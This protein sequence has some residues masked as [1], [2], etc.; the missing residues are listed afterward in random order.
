[1]LVLG[2]P[3]REHLQADLYLSRA[4]D[5]LPEVARA[6]RQLCPLRGDRPTLP[7]R[8]GEHRDRV[9]LGRYALAPV[10]LEGLNVARSSV[11]GTSRGVV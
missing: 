1:M 10:V 3:V 8:S 9:A 11:P 2:K 7:P 5:R 4:R 6:E